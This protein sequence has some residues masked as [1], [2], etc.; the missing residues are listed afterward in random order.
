[1]KIILSPY[2]QNPPNPNPKNYLYWNELVNLLHEHELIQIGINGEEQLCNDFRKNLS[3]DQLK[4][5]LLSSDLFIS[6]DNFFHH[7]AHVYG[8]KGIVIWAQSDPSLF[9]YPEHIN[10]LKDRKYLRHNQFAT[11]HEGEYKEEA[12]VRPEEIFKKISEFT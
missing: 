1:M 7:F 5:L 2:S 3:F 10:V 4:D 11:W 6:V 9:G 8:K 12:F